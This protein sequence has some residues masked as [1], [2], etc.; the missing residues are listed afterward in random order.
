MA[1]NH[2]TVIFDRKKKASEN[3]IGKIELQIRLTRTCR[4]YITVGEC[5]VPTTFYIP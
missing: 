5:T 4:K 3:G 1:E 2:V